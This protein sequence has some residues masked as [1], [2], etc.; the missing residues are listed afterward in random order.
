M[1]NRLTS[2]LSSADQ[3]EPKLLA[4]ASGKGGVGK[5]VISYNMAD[6]LARRKRVLLLDGDFHTGNLHLLG[7]VNPDYGWQDICFGR[8]SFAEAVVSLAD[9][10]DLLASAGGNTENAFPDMPRLAAFLGD[11]RKLAKDYDYVIIDTAS[12]IL[13]HTNLLLHTVDEVVLVTTPELTSIS[14]CYA[15]YKVLIG[16]NTNILASLLVNHEDREEELRYIRRKFTAITDRFLNNS[17]EFFGNLGYDRAL[18]EAVACQRGISDSA[19]QS[20]INQHF[21]VLAD[22]LSGQEIPESFNPETINSAPV[23][24]I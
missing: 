2:A 18:V 5:S 13:P 17:P 16:D 20:T 22:H 19:P 6:H 15:L 10:F 14:D 9:N 3:T 4:I 11:L 8:V 23:R 1:N 7:N 24:P 12:G 21:A